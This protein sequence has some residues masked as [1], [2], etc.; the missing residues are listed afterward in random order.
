VPSL[1]TS[2]RH[3]VS[4]M[5]V[6]EGDAAWLVTTPRLPIAVNGAGDAAA[7]LFLGH[8]LRARSAEKALAAT[9]AA[10]FAVIEA[11]AEAG[12]RELQLVGA[13][14]VLV[15]PRRHFATRRVR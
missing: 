8:Y 3:D 9:A 7:A 4:E 1:E 12:T 10:I 14:D 6:V 15:A 5:L 2:G 11:T 13:Q